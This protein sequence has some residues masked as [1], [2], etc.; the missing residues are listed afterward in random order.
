MSFLKKFGAIALQVGKVVPIAGPILGAIIPGT[1]DDAIIARATTSID[2][3]AGIIAQ[4]EIMGQA[5][6]LKGPDKLKAAT[7]AVAQLILASS[8][9]AG[10]EIADPVLFKAGAEKIAAGMA[11]CLNALKAEP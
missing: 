2:Q 11:D 5:L 9:V 10:R 4:A 3:I 1:K 7:P 8:A 6:D